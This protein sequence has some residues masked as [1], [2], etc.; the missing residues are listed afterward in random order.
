MDKLVIIRLN[1][2]FRNISPGSPIHRFRARTS[3]I[4]GL[5]HSLLQRKEQR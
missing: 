2:D 4:S 1:Y 5:M 3:I